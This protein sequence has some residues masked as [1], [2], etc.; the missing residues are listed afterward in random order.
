MPSAARAWSRRRA[1]ARSATGGAVALGGLAGG[2]PPGARSLAMAPTSLA[3][4]VVVAAAEVMLQ[5]DVEDDE[6]ITAAHLLQTQLGLA[7]GAV[8]P[9]D[10]DDGVGVAADHGLQWQLD[11]QVEVRRQQRPDVVDDL[12]LVGLEG[13]GG[14]VVAVA[15]QQPDAQVDQPVERQLEG[16][17][18]VDLRAG[19]EPRPEGA[20]KA[21][22]QQSV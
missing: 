22:L 7:G 6:Q 21:L 2:A 12:A 8:G 15:E 16:R 13:V 19:H 20:V 5:E 18:V 10:R 4:P 9:R 1:G 11:G 3:G 17:V 14:V